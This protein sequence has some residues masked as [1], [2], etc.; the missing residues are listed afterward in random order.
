MLEPAFAYADLGSWPDARRVAISLLAQKNR[1]FFK[2]FKEACKKALDDVP[3]DAELRQILSVRYSLIFLRKNQLI[4]NA[5]ILFV[6]GFRELG[7]LIC[8][9]NNRD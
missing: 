5:L 8:Q 1:I 9:Q 7:S 4:L 2:T 3:D 6:S